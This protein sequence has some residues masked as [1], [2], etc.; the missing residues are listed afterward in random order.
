MEPPVSLALPTAIAVAHKLNRTMCCRGRSQ[1]TNSTRVDWPF[2]AVL[3]PAIGVSEGQSLLRRGRSDSWLGCLRHHFTHTVAAVFRPARSKL[4][5]VGS[6][7][8]QRGA[9]SSPTRRK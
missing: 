6:P 2:Y 9:R 3:Y 5:P 7:L 1:L 8:L 4:D